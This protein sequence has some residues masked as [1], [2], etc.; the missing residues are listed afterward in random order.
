VRET[1]DKRKSEKE[2]AN[3]RD[4]GGGGRKETERHSTRKRNRAHAGER[5][6]ESEG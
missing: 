4:R 5:A 2:R 3:L 1:G 6:R